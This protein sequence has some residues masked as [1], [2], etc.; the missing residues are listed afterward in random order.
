M[1]KRRMNSVMVCAVWMLALV[2]MAQV[3]GQTPTEAVLKVDATDAITEDLDFLTGRTLTVGNGATFTYSAGASFGGSA[4]EFRTDIGLGTAATYN[5]GTGAGQVP[6]L[7]LGGVLSLAGAVEAQ[8]SVS[9]FAAA[10]TLVLDPTGSGVATIGVGSLTTPR[11]YALPDRSGVFAVVADAGGLVDVSDEV[12]GRLPNASLATMAQATIKGRASGAGTGDATD[13][14]ADQAMVILDGAT[15]PVARQSDIETSE[16]LL[17][18]QTASNSATVQ[19][20][21]GFTSTYRRYR[22]VIDGVQ[23]ATDA[24]AFCLRISDDGGST[25]KSTGNYS[26]SITMKPLGFGETQNDTTGQTQMWLTADQTFYY[27]SN[28]SGE[29]GFFTVEISD[30]STSRAALVKSW[31]SYMANDAGTTP[32]VFNETLGLWTAA[33]LAINGV[34]FFFSSGNIAT[35]RFRLYGI[36]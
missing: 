6:L 7:S 21:S 9:V 16:V 19:F 26:T 12:T 5:T 32:F 28:A 1:M 24:V 15:D 2:A 23:P 36:P 30:P 27:M 25:W 35:G 11:T 29:H 17:A 22:I 18:T 34:Q 13:L 3:Q 4:S 33:Q 31:G 20:T 8:N 10:P 14:S